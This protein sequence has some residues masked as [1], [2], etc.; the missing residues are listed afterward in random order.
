MQGIRPALIARISAQISAS[1]DLNQVCRWLIE[2]QHDPV[3]VDAGHLPALG[4]NSR[5]RVARPITARRAVLCAVWLVEEVDAG[6]C[7]LAGHLRFVAHPTAPEIKVA[8]DGQAR[9]NIGATALQLL[10]LIAASIKRLSPLA[11]VEIAPT[12]IPIIAAS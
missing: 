6:V 1:A 2:C 9:P 8:F 3:H 11:V 12:M 7:V 5:L 4:S 10:E